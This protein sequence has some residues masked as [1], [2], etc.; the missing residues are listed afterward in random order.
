MKMLI[1]LVIAFLALVYVYTFLKM[2]KKRKNNNINTVSEFNRKYLK[3]TNKKSVQQ[4]NG[5]ID[6]ITKDDL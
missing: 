4:Y 6:Y 5:K 1:I 2:R 3:T